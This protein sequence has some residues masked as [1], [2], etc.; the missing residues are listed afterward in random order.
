M[1]IIREFHVIEPP[2]SA[3]IQE[4]ALKALQTGSLLRLTL[5]SLQQ[6]PSTEEIF[7]EFRIAQVVKPDEGGMKITGPNAEGNSV[8]VNVPEDSA[9]STT[10]SIVN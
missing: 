9:L 5:R 7:V 3:E 1:P 10:A 8:V 2:T 6:V 4:R